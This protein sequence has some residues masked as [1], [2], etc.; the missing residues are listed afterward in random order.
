MTNPNT[1]QARGLT[2]GTVLFALF[3]VQALVV[4]V[5]LLAGSTGWL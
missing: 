4:G 1:G 5:A 3:S 2:L